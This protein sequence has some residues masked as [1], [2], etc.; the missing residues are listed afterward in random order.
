LRLALAQTRE[1][2]RHGE[3]CQD[4]IEGAQIQSLWVEA[5][6]V[7]VGKSPESFKEDVRE[8]VASWYRGRR[9]LYANDVKFRGVVEAFVIFG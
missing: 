6:E 5:L 3:W 4:E 9:E 7:A 1:Q 2:L 8:R